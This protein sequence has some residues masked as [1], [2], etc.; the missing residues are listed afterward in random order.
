MVDYSTTSWHN[1]PMF[2]ADKYREEI[3][4]ISLIERAKML[5]VLEDS[6]TSEQLEMSNEMEALHQHIIKQR[7]DSVKQGNAK[8]IPW[9]EIEQELFG[10][11]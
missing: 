4:S 3:S 6:I 7:M 8:L 9:K 2:D 1:N 11:A 10:N 5:C